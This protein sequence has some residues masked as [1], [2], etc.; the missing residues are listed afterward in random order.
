[1]KRRT[2]NNVLKAGRLIQKKGYEKKESLEM[3]IK[4]FDEMELLN[5]GM[6]IEWR[7]NQI[8]NKETWEQEAELYKY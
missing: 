4:I 8:V 3:A 6:S 2:Y 1:M 7:I 5:N